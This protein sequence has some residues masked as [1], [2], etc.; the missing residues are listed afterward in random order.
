MTSNDD[1]A[2]KIK[3]ITAEIFPGTAESTVQAWARTRMFGPPAGKVGRAYVWF[4]SQVIAG[5]KAAGKLDADGRPVPT[6][7]G[8]GAH[9]WFPQGPHYDTDGTL[10][11]ARQEVLTMFGVPGK[12]STAA[13]SYRWM[14]QGIRGFP[15]DPDRHL[16]TRPLWRVDRLT[17]WADAQGI[18]YDLPADPQ[19]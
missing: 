5:A 18:D 1:P 6:S 16:M 17:A 14:V 8:V 12:R 11:L 4:R 9:R 15:T 7:R 13:V 3:Q 10:L 19:R 2:M